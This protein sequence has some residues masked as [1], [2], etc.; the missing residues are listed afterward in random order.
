MVSKGEETLNVGLGERFPLASRAAS[1]PGINAF[2]RPLS[3][4]TDITA[5]MKLGPLCADQ[6]A[7]RTPFETLLGCLNC[8]K[9][10]RQLS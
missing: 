6:R 5:A 8:R 10:A 1:P 9:E 7:A 3:A 2:A 4:M